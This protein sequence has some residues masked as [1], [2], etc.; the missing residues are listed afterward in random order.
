M[1]KWKTY[2]ANLLMSENADG[3]TTFQRTLY[4]DHDASLGME[5][6]SGVHEWTVVTPND[7]ANMYAGVAE[8]ICDKRLYPSGT[9]AWTMYFH[10][11]SLCSKDTLRTARQKQQR[12]KTMTHFDGE[13]DPD[14]KKTRVSH[15]TAVKVLVDMYNGASSGLD[16]LRPLGRPSL[17][18]LA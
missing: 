16:L 3:V 18:V 8:E 17:L 9:Q 6:T 15:G 2:N 11:G 5:L 4:A 13:Q 10:D 1:M 14:W 7:V 12:A